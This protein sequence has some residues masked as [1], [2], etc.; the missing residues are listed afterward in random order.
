ME[1]KIELA[2]KVVDLIKKDLS[3]TD[4]KIFLELVEIL[5]KFND[6]Y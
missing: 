5:Y 4:I 2:K 3:P 6:E 1:E